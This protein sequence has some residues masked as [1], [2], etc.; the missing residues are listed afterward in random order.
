VR[1]ETIVL[2]RC[3]TQSVQLARRAFTRRTDRLSTNPLERIAMINA[4]ASR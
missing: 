2:E 4:V 1:G 3:V